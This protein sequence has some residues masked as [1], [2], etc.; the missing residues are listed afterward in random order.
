MSDPDA[1]NVTGGFRTLMDCAKGLVSEK[2]GGNLVDYGGGPKK[3]H[4]NLKPRKQKR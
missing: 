2:C 4:Y 3:R 1:Q